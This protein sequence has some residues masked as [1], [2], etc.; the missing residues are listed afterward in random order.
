MSASP[1]LQHR[2]SGMRVNPLHSQLRESQK[3]TISPA[4]KLKR[5]GSRSGIILGPKFVGGGK[6]RQVFVERPELV[7]AANGEVGVE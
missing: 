4:P 5:F 1:F 7:G 3:T 2:Q 6:A